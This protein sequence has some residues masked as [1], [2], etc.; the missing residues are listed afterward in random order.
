[1]E[2]MGLAPGASPDRVVFLNSAAEAVEG[3]S[4]VQESAPER[5]ELK[6]DLLADLDG[7]SHPGAILASST[8]GYRVSELT[9]RCTSTPERVVVAHPFNPVYLLPLVELVAGPGTSRAVMDRAADFYAMVGKTVLRLE[10]EVDGFVADRLQEAMWREALHMLANGEATVEQLDL[11]IT[12]GPGL[13]WALMGP[14]LT[15]HLAGGEGGMAHM[16]DH[17]GPSLSAPWTR[18]KAPELTPDLRAAAVA[19]C[20]EEAAGRS[21]G[22]LVRERDRGLVA[23]LR[24]LQEIKA[25]TPGEG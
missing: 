19:G 13:R 10:R 5:L 20:E 1:M 18:L 6:Q 17:F 4:L 25:V 9:A 21:V 12:A 14:M 23:I 24:A 16:L 7:W 3:A 8:S 11:S 2:A 22:D 15:F